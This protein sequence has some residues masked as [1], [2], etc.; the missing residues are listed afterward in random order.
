MLVK[1]FVF[2]DYLKVDLYSSSSHQTSVF[3]ALGLLSLVLLM[4]R[5]GATEYRVGDSNGWTLNDVSYGQWAEM[6]RFQVGDSLCKLFEFSVLTSILKMKMLQISYLVY[7]YGTEVVVLTL[8][9]I[10]S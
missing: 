1:K 7:A 9:V 6:K 4:Q 5:V 2:L 8:K 3:H 10:R